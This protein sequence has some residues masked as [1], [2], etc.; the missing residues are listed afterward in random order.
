MP[1]IQPKQEIKKLLLNTGLYRFAQ[2]KNQFHVLPYHSVVDNPNPFFPQVSLS[3]FEKHMAH[4]AKNYRVIDFE[5]LMERIRSKES[6]RKCVVITFDDGF[7]DNLEVVAPVL[8]KYNFPATIFLTTDFIDNKTTP[9]FLKFRFAFQTTK[10]KILEIDM[11]D[12]HFSF[13][14][15]TQGHRLDASNKVMG[16]LRK[17][18]EQDQSGSVGIACSRGGIHAYQ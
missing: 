5:T 13:S 9:W 11:G 18:S 7:L 2:L 12:T 15:K 8:K 4:L 16:H 17:L 6:I 14:L 1:M 3:L 10:E